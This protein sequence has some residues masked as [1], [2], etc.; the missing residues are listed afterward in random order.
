MCLMLKNSR[1]RIFTW[2]LMVREGLTYIHLK[3]VYLSRWNQ[4]EHDQKNAL[5]VDKKG[6][7]YS[8]KW[9]KLFGYSSVLSN[10][11]IYY[12]NI[13]FDMRDTQKFIHQ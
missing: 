1:S 3:L 8:S 13:E 12:C 10:K 6:Y 5:G 4:V 9:T 2:P 7:I 11:G